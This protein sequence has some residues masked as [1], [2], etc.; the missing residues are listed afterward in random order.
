MMQ[1]SSPRQL[2]LQVLGLFV[3]GTRRYNSRL[4]IARKSDLVTL[5]SE[6]EKRTFGQY[7]LLRSSLVKIIHSHVL[8]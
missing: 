4:S 2:E 3:F 6:G 8:T 5:K 1:R 7:Q